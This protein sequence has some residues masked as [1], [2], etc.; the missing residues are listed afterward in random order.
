LK[1]EPTTGPIPNNEFS[2]ANGNY[3]VSAERQAVESAGLSFYNLPVT[4]S[5]AF[6]KE[7]FD[8]FIPTF[9]EASSKGPLLIHCTSGHRSSVYTIAYLAMQDPTVRCVDWAIKEARRVGESLDLVQ[10]DID[11]D[12]KFWRSTLAC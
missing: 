5:A 4:G 7:Q 11:K 8:S 1:S 12:I 3:N 6:T 10:S 2:D 9:D